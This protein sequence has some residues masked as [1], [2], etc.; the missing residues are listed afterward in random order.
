MTALSRRAFL[1]SVAVGTIVSRSDATPCHRT[2]TVRLNCGRCIAYTEYGN[3][4]GR[5]VIAYHHGMP[6]SRREAEILLPALMCRPDVRVIA[7][8]RPG[9]GDS[10]PSSSAEYTAWVRDLTVCLDALGVDRIALAGTSA[11]TPYMLATAVALS[12]RVM[13]VSI[14]V[15]VS[16]LVER[17]D[18][19]VQGVGPRLAQG[20]A[21]APNAT[22]FGFLAVASRVGNHPDLAP[23][24]LRPMSSADEVL[25]RDPA[26]LEL[27]ASF[28]R[29]TARDG[30]RRLVAEMRQLTQ[31]WCIPLAEVS[32]PTTFFLGACD[33]H[34]PAALSEEMARRVPGAVIRRYP[35]ESHFSLPVNAAAAV[36]DAAIG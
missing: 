12:D 10:D 1:G 32:V 6:S 17:C 29:A 4:V 31:P 19:P 25:L 28:M 33:R 3:P 7:F 5:R 30:G 15:P 36:L 26:K 2:G 22:R 8:D 34:W 18:V 21:L 24:Y 27:V 35:G 13:S 11:G 20:C 9:I 16:S 23:R 14:A